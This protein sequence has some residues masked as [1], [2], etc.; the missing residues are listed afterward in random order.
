MGRTSLPWLI[1]AFLS[2]ALLAAS[3]ERPAGAQQ[4]RPP[5]G[6]TLRISPTSDRPTV[7]L[8]DPQ[9]SSVTEKPEAPHKAAAPV[10]APP[11]P[12]PAPSVTP[13]KPLGD[14][15]LRDILKPLQ[16]TPAENAGGTPNV[17]P[18]SPETAEKPPTPAA[19]SSPA[20]SPEPAP[21]AADPLKP[22]SDPQDSGP[23]EIEASSFKGVVPGVSTVADVEKAW[24]APKEIQKRDGSLVQLYSVQP[25]ERVEVHSMADRVTC[26]VIRL[27]RP[28]PASGAAEQLGLSRIRPVLISDELGEILGQSYPER[29]V[30]FSFEPGEKPGKPSMKVAQ[31]V[32]EPISA[33]PFILRAET[34][35]KSRY[36][37]CR[38]DLEEALK[39]QAGNA[40]AHWL[41]SR[42][43]SV[44]GEH[45][46]ALPAANEAVRLEPQNPQYRVTRAQVLA[47][48]GRLAEAMDEAA[49]AAQLSQQRPH[50]KARAL[51]LLGDLSASGMEP[52][53]RRAIQYHSEALSTAD[54][55]SNNRHP[56]I[57]IAAKEVLIDA[58]LGA[59]HD[60]AWGKWRD[61]KDAVARWLNRAAALAEELIRNEGE[62]E[63]HRFRVAT[64]ALAACVGLRGQMD[65]QP[66]TAEAIR[67]GEA[68]IAAADDPSR[69]ADLQWDLGVSLYDTLQICQMRSEH[70]MA[71]KYGEQAV[72][73]LE[74]GE[75]KKQS[76]AT[77]YL[78]GRL[79]FRMGAVSALRE[80]NHTQA[81]TWFDK[82]VPLLEKPAPKEVLADL[83]RHGETFV[84]MAVSYWETGQRPKAVALTTRGVELM[85]E[86]AR[87][88]AMDFAALSVP[89]A[90]LANM[91]RQLGEADKA[92]RFQQMAEQMKDSKLR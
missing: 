63:E 48:T 90:N 58:H 1:A 85:A 9:G 11:S 81:V 80:Q 49:Q 3:T 79:Y 43:L 13:D 14:S 17:A 16:P 34:Y 88:G 33:E 73:Y 92:N 22:I 44:S 61:K 37:P 67:T 65:P 77:T 50:V 64:R 47:Q 27:Q 26:L 5:A 24:G 31:I 7:S 32:L 39:I 6:T 91:H 74:Q 89:Y 69:K 8:S 2:A 70:D 15:E 10:D 53:Y 19:A 41:Y 76:P 83:G 78:L 87:R 71:L 21:P 86:A 36:E 52:D 55:L 35:L 25:F 12:A 82:A 72:R 20:P 66:W 30:L 23:V 75:A 4:A 38:R 62:S 57:R 84:S 18:A 45:D 68:M 51:C 40:R 46:K 54:P 59:A 60:I 56:A 28:A 42:V 29:G